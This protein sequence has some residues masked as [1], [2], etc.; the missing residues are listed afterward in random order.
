MLN[1]H[2][3]LCEWQQHIFLIGPGGTGKSTVGP[4]LAA[5]L[6]R[7]FVDLDLQFIDAH[8]NIGEFIR[9]HGYSKYAEENAQLFFRLI[10]A[11]QTSA[12]FALSSGL[13][14]TNA[15]VAQ[16]EKSRSLVTARGIA[17]LQLPLQDRHAAMEMI[18]ARQLGRGFGL[19]AKREREK[20][21]ARIDTY[22]ALANLVIVSREAPS[23]LHPT[24]QI[25]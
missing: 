23:E 24:S 22:L 13:L 8:G 17:I 11:Q 20:F 2:A 3:Q 7:P 4:H 10:D 12:V 15:P 9:M 25:N 18:V 16:I 14:A 6:A 21:S 1:I 19:N 5:L